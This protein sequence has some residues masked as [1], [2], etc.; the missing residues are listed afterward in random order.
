MEGGMLP[1][2]AV[3]EAKIWEMQGDTEKDNCKER[4]KAGQGEPEA[5]SRFSSG[6]RPGTSTRCFSLVFMLVQI[7][8]Q[9]TLKAINKVHSC[10]LWGS[11]LSLQISQSRFPFQAHWNIIMVN[12]VW[13]SM[14][15]MIPREKFTLG[16]TP[17]FHPIEV[18]IMKS[19]FPIPGFVI[20]LPPASCK[21]ALEL[22]QEA[23][24]TAD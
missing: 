10:L 8:I 7:W 17:K 3:P 14:P 21:S 18:M 9:L 12:L 23:W 22:T 19:H 13:I 1:S 5:H 16:G 4:G 2:V 11:C 24:L 6:S 20:E 15:F